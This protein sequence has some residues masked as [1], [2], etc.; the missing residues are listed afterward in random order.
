[1]LSL[2]FSYLHPQQVLLAGQV[3]RLWKKIAYSPALWRNVSFRA[4]HGGIQVANLDYF[5]H[6]IGVRFTELCIC[7]LATDLITPNV[8]HE[9]ANKC[10]KLHSLTLDFSTA[11]QLHDFTDLQTFPSRLRSL[12]ICL[13][14]NIF[15]EGFLRKVYTFISG[16]EFLH[17]IGESTN[18]FLKL[19]CRDLR[20]GRG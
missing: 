2:I 19:D 16:V 12:T 9:L 13:S 1:V 4:N 10:P 5:V 15:L 7:E 17:I 8:L 20:E 11:M 3:C 6:L 14:E 18:E